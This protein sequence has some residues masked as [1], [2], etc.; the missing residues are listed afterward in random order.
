[1]KKYF[2]YFVTLELKPLLASLVRTGGTFFIIMFTLNFLDKYLFGESFDAAITSSISIWHTL[3][4]GAI[5][6]SLVP[7]VFRGFS[8]WQYLEN[9]ELTNSNCNVIHESWE[10]Q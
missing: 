3:L 6:I 10:K 7:M 9:H 4:K 2:H 1:M 8:K 5:L